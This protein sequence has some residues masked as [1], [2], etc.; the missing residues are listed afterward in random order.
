MVV[1]IA[2]L[3]IFILNLLIIWSTALSGKGTKYTPAGI[4]IWAFIMVYLP[5][6]PQPQFTSVFTWY[7]IGATILFFGSVL[8]IA[9]RIKFIQAGPFF[10]Y[11]QPPKL[12]TDGP[13]KLVRHPQSLAFILIFS[14]ITIARGVINCLVLIPVIIL[15]HWVE[16]WLEEKII[17]EHKF[18]QQY[19]KYQET[20]GMFLPK[21]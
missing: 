5:F 14:G 10:D 15:F 7:I 4:I 21:F 1:Q 17:L 12:I 19:K 6:T 8:L 9:A 2:W 20:T 18:P 3:F 13:Y 16:S 11:A